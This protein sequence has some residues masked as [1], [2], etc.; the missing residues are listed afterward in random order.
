M[1][2][3]DRERLRRTMAS[4]GI[5]SDV[6]VFDTLVPEHMRARIAEVAAGPPPVDDPDYTVSGE[7][8]RGGMAV[9]WLAEQVPLARDVAIKQS[10]DPSDAEAQL[11][12]LREALIM[13]QLE[14]PNIAPVHALIG[15]ARR[16]AVVMKRL[17]GHTWDALIHDDACPLERHLEI[18]MQVANAVDFAHARG[19]FHRDLKP[20]NVMV[21][22]F[23]EVTVLDWG[24]ARRAS[25]PASDAIVGTPR[26]MAPEMAEG[27]ADART[28]VF[29]LGAT[30]HEV[31][32]GEPRHRGESALEVL[33]AAM[34]VAPFAYDAAV[35]EE[36]AAICNRAC[37]RDSDA[38]FPSVAALREAVASF[39]A[40]RA[41]NTLSDAAGQQLAALR[42]G[43]I[44]SGMRYSDIQYLFA[45]ARSA[46]EAALRVW[47]ESP[48]AR[49]GLHDTLCAMIDYEIGRH[50][51]DAALALVEMLD[52]PDPARHARVLA[53]IRERATERE[54]VRAMERDHDPA[55]GAPDRRRA[56]RAIAIAT[57]AMTIVAA[58]Q[59]VFF[60]AYRTTTQRL[61]IVGAVVLATMAAIVGYWRT[62]GSWNLV[63]RRIAF[64][65][66]GIVVVSFGSRVSGYVAGTPPAQ[67]LISDAYILGLGG[68]ALA[69]YHR[70]GPWLALLSCAVAG[71]GTALP[72]YTDELFIGLSVFVPAAFLLLQRRAPEPGAERH[73]RADSPEA[74]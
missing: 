67:V 12:L 50:H 54:R 34:H 51:P 25:D 41:A 45:L 13:G 2:E 59:R 3:D 60:P 33:Y 37:A 63:N 24:V 15:D 61:T 16:P 71:I 38:R 58:A 56:W 64:I 43:I 49:G 31:L 44:D 36:L 22:A 19:V 40:H 65:C 73:E 27:R 11:L 66:L 35:P 47:P 23:G 18:F 70:I 52:P 32:T 21:G 14:H 8:G 68:A 20:A 48:P 7:L 53:L 30:L 1:S 29:L 74:G 46:Y 42:R 69:A 55:V 6:S 39:R 72:E 4:Q 5:H 9:V 10:I 62:R 26:Y 17:A 57:L 28:D